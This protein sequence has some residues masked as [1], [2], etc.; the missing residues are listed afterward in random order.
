M[1][2]ESFCGPTGATAWGVSHDATRVGHLCFMKTT[3]I[4]KK[5]H[6]TEK[7][8]FHSNEFEDASEKRSVVPSK[9]ADLFQKSYQNDGRQ[10]WNFASLMHHW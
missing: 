10:D 9:L 8:N 5:I 4:N 7:K 6:K 2:D 3:S 1:C